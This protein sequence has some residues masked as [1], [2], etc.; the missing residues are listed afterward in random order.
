MEILY[1][2]EQPMSA[3]PQEAATDEV[4]IGGGKTQRVTALLFSNKYFDSMEGSRLYRER[5]EE[6]KLVDQLGFD[7]IMLNEH[8]TAPF[9]MSPR[10]NL[11]ASILAAITKNVKI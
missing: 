9:C 2:T 10:I 4:P 5:I 6:Y 3:Y 11:F 7:G 8:H 1:F